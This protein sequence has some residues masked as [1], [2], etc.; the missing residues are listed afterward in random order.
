KSVEDYLKKHY[1]RT[2]GDM[3]AA[4]ILYEIRDGSGKYATIPKY[5]AT[6][7]D[8]SDRTTITYRAIEKIASTLDFEDTLRLVHLPK[9][10]P[11]SFT[12]PARKPGK[13]DIEKVFENL[14]NDVTKIFKVTV[15]DLCDPPYQD[16]AIKEC[17]KGKNIETWDWKKLDMCPDVIF[18]AAP[19]LTK[20]HLYWSGRNVVLHGWMGLCRLGHVEKIIVHVEQK[21][22]WITCMEEFSS[23]LHQLDGQTKHKPIGPVHVALIDDGVAIQELPIECPVGITGYSCHTQ[24]GSP[25]SSRSSSPTRSRSNSFIRTRPHYQSS[26][27]HGTTMAVQI[28]R[29]CP[30]ARLH[31]I[32]LEDNTNSRDGKRSITPESA[33]HAI[34][35]AIDSQADIISMSWTIDIPSDID[36]NPNFRLLREALQRADQRN[37]LMFCSA[38][39]RGA[40]NPATFPAQASANIFRIGAAK[41]SGQMVDNVGSPDNVDYTCP[42][43][44]VN[45]EWLDP[46]GVMRTDWHTGSSVATALAAGLAALILYCVQVL[47]ARGD[48]E[49]ELQKASA[50]LKKLKTPDGMK[51]ALGV[52]QDDA[53]YLAVWNIF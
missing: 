49:D 13:T 46:S 32:K 3:A 9:L 6:Y 29:I 30:K 27:G 25:S 38:S 11:L 7:F 40:N 10:E 48:T 5:K 45:T 44:S 33:A 34:N 14:F 43:D 51:K 22:G 18:E 16:A 15:D 39:D 52:M 24:P 28:Y 21:H 26:G 37:I 35:N 19:G 12:T 4:K 2:R 42:G 1:I 41:Q 47:V 31:V 36:E 50:S 8:I 23:K 53:K 17:L 20:L